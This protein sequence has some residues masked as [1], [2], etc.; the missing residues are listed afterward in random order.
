M[1][2]SWETAARYVYKHTTFSLSIPYSY[3]FRP[4]IQSIVYSPQ[5]IEIRGTY[6][7]S[8]QF[9]EPPKYNPQ[10]FE[11]KGVESVL[12]QNLLDKQQLK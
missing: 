6:W 1:I 5:G 9:T 3:A 8:K 11:N 2:T 12:H 10:I 4:V 7:E